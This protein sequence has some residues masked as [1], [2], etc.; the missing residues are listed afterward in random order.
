MKIYHI[1][2]SLIQVHNALFTVLSSQG[3]A[4]QVMFT[5]PIEI[6]KIRMQVAGE[7]WCETRCIGPSKRTWFYWPVQGS[8]IVCVVSEL[9]REFYQ[10]QF[11]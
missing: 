6:V 10:V 4:A 5:N 11:L 2:S 8:Y 1:I 9:N 3:G 7:S